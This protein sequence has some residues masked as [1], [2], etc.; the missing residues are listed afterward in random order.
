MYF[1]FGHNCTSEI[2]NG[3]IAKDCEAQIPGPDGSRQGLRIF[4]LANPPPKPVLR[5]QENYPHVKCWSREDY[6]KLKKKKRGVTDGEATSVLTK[7]KPG[8]PT[9]SSTLDTDDHSKHFYLE[10]EDGTPISRED[11]VEMSVKARMTWEELLKKGMAPVTFC[12]I[13]KAAWEFYWYSMAAYPEFDFIMLCK[14]GEWKLRQWSID[15][16]SSWTRT[17]GV[18]IVNPPKAEDL[19]NPTLIQMDLKG[20]DNCEVGIPNNSD[21]S[22]TRCPIVLEVEEDDNASIQQVSPPMPPTS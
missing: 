2:V 3:S 8:R 18:R 1:T 21:K 9:K 15:S 6:S 5:E 12:K 14:N 19:N 11:I 16:Y 10:H 4:S 20:A 17:S 13:T 7:R 22:D